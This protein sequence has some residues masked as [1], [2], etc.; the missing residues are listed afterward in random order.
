[1]PQIELIKDSFLKDKPGEILFRKSRPTFIIN[2]R[3]AL[4]SKTSLANNVL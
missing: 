2:K 4:S 3:N 1:M